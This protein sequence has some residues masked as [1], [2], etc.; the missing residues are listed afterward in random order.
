MRRAASLILLS[1]LGACA[2]P[3]HGVDRAAFEHS[4]LISFD[5]REIFRTAPDV[6]PAIGEDGKL[7]LERAPRDEA[8]CEKRMDGKLVVRCRPS[9]Q[10][11]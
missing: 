3:Y 11:A 7:K 1:A 10:R 5:R 6:V 4:P 9:R 2:D 8:K